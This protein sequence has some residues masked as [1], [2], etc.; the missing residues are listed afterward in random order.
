MMITLSLGRCS[1]IS[2][3]VPKVAL[4]DSLPKPDSSGH[5][6]APVMEMKY[7]T[8]SVLENTGI[9]K[10]LRFFGNHSITL[11]PDLLKEFK[12]WGSVEIP[13]GELLS[14]EGRQIG[15]G[16]FKISE[17]AG[18]DRKGL[19]QFET[20]L[21]L[22]PAGVWV[23]SVSSSTP[24]ELAQKVL[25]GLVNITLSFSS[26]DAGSAELSVNAEDSAAAKP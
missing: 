11:S 22:S 26:V 19:D 7:K 2:P 13:I 25:E 14:G 18:L 20:T 21:E 3:S 15:I 1:P 17:E 23:L 12:D 6:E 24:A 4:R 9:A 10:T 16:Y 8:Y 5:A